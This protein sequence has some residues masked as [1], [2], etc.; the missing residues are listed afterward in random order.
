[1]LEKLGPAEYR[2]KKL[3]EDVNDPE[4][5]RTV[6]CTGQAEM[7]IAL[8]AS[9]DIHGILLSTYGHDTSAFFLPELAKW[10]YMDSTYNEDYILA[11]SGIV[12]SPKE[13]FNASVM[14]VARDE[15]LATK[16]QGPSWERTVYVDSSDDIRATYLG[17]SN[18]YAWIVIGSNLIQEYADPFRTNLVMYDAPFFHEYPDDPTTV[19][20]SS[21]EGY[22]TWESSSLSLG[23]RL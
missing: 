20:F 22:P 7:L 18:P 14:G 9:I 21:R 17:D 12:A 5:Y 8:A 3:V 23:C 11:S 1:M 15:F 4:V 13:F 16:I 6:L 2:I 10:V 19:A